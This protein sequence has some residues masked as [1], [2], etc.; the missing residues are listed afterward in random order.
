MKQYLLIV[1][2]LSSPVYGLSQSVLDRLGDI[3]NAR[4]LERLDVFFQEWS[5]YSI[6]AKKTVKNDTIIELEHIYRTLTDD[7]NNSK[8]TH[9]PKKLIPNPKY[10][11]PQNRISYGI[12][13][14]GWNLNKLKVMSEFTSNGTRSFKETTLKKAIKRKRSFNTQYS[15]STFFKDVDYKKEISFHPLIPSKEVATCHLK[16]E[17]LAFEEFIGFQ[18]RYLKRRTIPNPSEEV[19][20][21]IDFLKKVVLTQNDLTLYQDGPGIKFITLNK[22]L[23]QAIVFHY[24]VCGLGYKPIIMKKTSEGKWEIIE[25]SEIVERLRNEN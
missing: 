17:Y 10:F 6:Q 8:I 21:R 7:F 1:F 9:D 14:G 18:N 3:Y 16:G 4:S 5:N 20:E 11:I 13:A 22:R 23:D 2:L 19:V 12:K 15:F 25:F 24:S